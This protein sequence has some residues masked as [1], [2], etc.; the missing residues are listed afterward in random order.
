M[1][2]HGCKGE[3]FAH[4]PGQVSCQAAGEFLQTGKVQQYIIGFAAIVIVVIAL[5]VAQTG[6]F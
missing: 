4:S 3:F 2:E 6:W 5:L 1:D